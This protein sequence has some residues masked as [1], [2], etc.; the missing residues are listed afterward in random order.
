M[1]KLIAMLLALLLLPCCSLAD[2]FMSFT[3]GPDDAAETLVISGSISSEMKNLFQDACP[4]VALTVRYDNLSTDAIVQALTNHDSTVDVYEMQADY[5]FTRMLEKGLAANLSASEVLSVDAQLMD[6]A[7][8]SLLTDKDGL[9]R[10]YPSEMRLQR[11]YI[12][13]GLWH[14]V[15]GDE[16]LPTTMEA[17]L[18][19]WLDWEKNHAADYP[20][21]DF[22][23][24][25]IYDQW[26]EL[27]IEQYAMQ[28]EQPGQ[29]L[30]LNA[31]ALR[32]ALELLAEINE[33][34]LQAG[35]FTT[36]EDYNDGWMETAPI[37]SRGMGE[38]VMQTF[39]VF[40]T[41]LSPE[42]YGADWTHRSVLPLTFAAG[43][44]LK[45]HATMNVYVIN[46]YSQHQEA[47]LRL[48]ECAAQVESN[49][50]VAYAIH[51]QLTEPY[52]DPDY[53]WW[54]ALFRESKEEAETALNAGDIADIPELE[55][56]L[57]RAA[58]QLEQVEQSRWLISEADM[59]EYRAISD[60]LDFHTQ[61][62]YGGHRNNAQA[63][64][65]ELCTRYCAG[66][67]SLDL[68]LS[69]MTNRLSMMARE[70]E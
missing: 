64:I 49:P 24:G 18:T 25:F 11:W 32:H 26:C 48:I 53:E 31:P 2:E 7:I 8:L 67:T 42:L 22:I 66:N 61:S 46:P 39:S 69:E 35:R 58:Y 4:D 38:Q 55:E 54:V 5:V 34:R 50:H 1:K 12:S 47:A 41:G 43:D 9:L 6:P 65:Q 60:Q 52:E 21:V 40:D 19:A 27:L 68:F 10:A 33:A 29:S 62:L 44:P 70:N 63:L 36:R 51:P 28:Y 57:A 59:A 23:E 14:A 3:F 15:W 13:E 20:E 16:P 30:D 45:F 37:I 56:A 17:L